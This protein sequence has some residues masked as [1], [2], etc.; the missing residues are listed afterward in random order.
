LVARELE[1]RWEETLRSQRELQERYDRLQAEE[2][3]GLTPAERASIEALAGEL[4]ALWAD[5]GTPAEERQAVVRCLVE[6]V[7]VNGEG[8][9]EV[10]AVAIH[11]SGGFVSHLEIRRPVG[12]YQRLRDYAQLKERLAELRRQ[13]KTSREI[14]DSLNAEGFRPPRQDRGFTEKVVRMLLSRVG[15]SGVRDDPAADAALL[16]PDEYWLTDLQRELGIPRTVL[17]PWCARGWVHA[18][19]LMVKCRRWVV[20]AD[21]EEKDRLRRLYAARDRAPAQPHPAELTT[22]KRRPEP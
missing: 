22:P 1:R 4:P 19:K 13:G 15:L 5:P 6:R 18:R 2:P 11:W 20:W 3:R 7:V 14:A 8:H 16:C 21:A 17:T 12:G 9:T 10:V